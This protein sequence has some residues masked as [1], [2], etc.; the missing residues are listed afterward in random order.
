ML[1][2][3]A[4]P[5]S[6]ASA[7]TALYG[8]LPPN[9]DPSAYNYLQVSSQGP[10]YSSFL[11]SSSAVLTDVKV[12]LTLADS[13]AGGSVAVGLFGDSTTCSTGPAHCPGTLIQ[14][15]GTVSDSQVTAAGAYD[16]PVNPGISLS[17]NTRYWIGMNSSSSE[18]E[19]AL[20]GSLAGTGD[21]AN[22][23]YCYYQSNVGLT[24][25]PGR[26]QPRTASYWLTCQ[27]NSTPYEFEEIVDPFVMQVS[28]S[29]NTSAAPTLSL[30]GILVLTLLLAASA[31]LFL[32]RSRPAAN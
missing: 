14:Q 20:T 9:T 23:Y 10:L 12:Y 19:W 3:T 29:P 7:Q 21:I 32:R 30:T 25:V 13:P 8:N 16:I 11:S 18:I 31:V 6:A 5:A 28:G 26:P 4:L 17:A 1:S 22:E 2:A 24:A 15:I 27:Y